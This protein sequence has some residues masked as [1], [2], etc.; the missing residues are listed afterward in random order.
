MAEARPFR[1]GILLQAFAVQQLA[2]NL[3]RAELGDTMAPPRFAFQSLLGVRGPMTPGELARVLGMA[4]TTVS[5]WINR[6]EGEGAVTRT[7]N[8]EDGR[9]VLVELTQLGREQLDEAMPHFRRA[10]L[11]LHD[12]LGDDAETVWESLAILIEA[13]RTALASSTRSQ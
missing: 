10:Y 13:L 5:S 1:E 2:G 7:R 3:L 11:A 6:L 8:A 9:S 4:P 12:A